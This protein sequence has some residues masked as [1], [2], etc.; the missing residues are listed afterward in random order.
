MT[1]RQQ[2][3]LEQTIGLFN[4]AEIPYSSWQHRPILNFETDAEVAKELGWTAEP[5]KSLFLKFKDGRHCLLFTHRDARLNSKAIKQL[6]GK[7]P[8]VCGDQ[9][10]QQL[11]GC[12]PGAVGPF[13]LPESIPLILDP[14]L[15]H[16]PELMFTPGP[17]EI[18]FAFATSGLISLTEE[19]PNPVLW[20]EES[21][22]KTPVTAQPVAY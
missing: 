20:L 12:T 4:R 22:G 17:P 8:S 9:E 13:A 3:L 6:M 18:T 19:L 1:E 14:R 21:C 10:M 5:T 15:L 11:L 2:Q 7:R 16:Y